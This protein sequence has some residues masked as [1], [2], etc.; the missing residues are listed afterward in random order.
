MYFKKALQFAYYLNDQF[1]EVQYY[2][3]IA[4]S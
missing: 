4:R 1:S 2:E 3:M